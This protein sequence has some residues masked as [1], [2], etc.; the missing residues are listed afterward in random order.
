MVT[1][2]SFKVSWKFVSSNVAVPASINYTNVSDSSLTAISALTSPLVPQDF[3]Q[4]QGGGRAE[5]EEGDIAK[6]CAEK[7]NMLRQPTVLNYEC[8]AGNIIMISQSH[9][10]L[11]VNPMTIWCFW[12]SAST[13]SLLFWA[14]CHFGNWT[15]VAV[16]CAPSFDLLIC[17]NVCTLAP[18]PW[19]AIVYRVLRK[20]WRYSQGL[21]GLTTTVWRQILG[22]KRMGWASLDE[23][24]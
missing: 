16:C 18:P 9:I 6:F 23:A 24:L 14:V 20:G 13:I 5:L 1:L 21:C 17:A 11:I 8:I 10:Y 19:R 15:R 3:W 22:E 12:G 2:F 4:I 7:G